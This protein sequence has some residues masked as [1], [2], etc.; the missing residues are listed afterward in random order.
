MRLAGLSTYVETQHDDFEEVVGRGEID[1]VHDQSLVVSEARLAVDVGLRG[2]WGLSVMLPLRTVTTSIRYLDTAGTEVQLLR[3][4][5]HHRNETVT[6]LAD[7]TVMGSVAGKVAGWR[8]AARA[9]VSVPIGRTEE[10][11]F[12]LGDRMI[13]HQHIQM[14]SGTVNPVLAADV[15]RAFG[16]WRVGGFAF[17]QQALYENGKGYQAGDRYAGGVTAQRALGGGWS[18]RGGAEAQAETAERWGG[19]VHTDDGNRGRFDAMLTGGGAWAATPRLTIDLA[20]KVP[21]YTHVVG[22]QLDMPAIVEVGASWRFGARPAAA[23]AEEPHDHGDEHHH[24]H[25]DEHAHGDEHGDEPYVHPDTTGLDVQDV[26]E[27]APVPGKVTIVD[28]WAEWCEPCKILE[29]AL[30]E[31]ARA[32]PDTVAIRRIDAADWDSAVVARYLT[33]GGFSL[34]HLKI[35]DASGKLV[36]ERTPGDGELDALIEEVRALAAP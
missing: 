2:R 28:F 35:Y 30:I 33:P 13:A 12:A 36:L 34:P 1:L 16:T 19:I 27:V 11:P 17:T 5:I 31:I 20:V 21:V 23:P 3:P 29:P 7:P 10:D 4:G 25:G 26:Q 6:G 8:L 15:G 18:V 22:G 32:H 14:G 24:D 9:G